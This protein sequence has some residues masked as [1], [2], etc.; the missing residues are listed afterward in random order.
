MKPRRLQSDTISS[1]FVSLA[2]LVFP[3]DCYFNSACAKALHTLR[4]L[5]YG[6][7]GRLQG[8]SAAAIMQGRLEGAAS[9]RLPGGRRYRNGRVN[10]RFYRYWA[11]NIFKT[12]LRILTLRDRLDMLLEKQPAGI[13]Y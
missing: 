2:I 4:G 7:R 1:S 5:L 10:S 9:G 6:T 3:L 13:A 12:S 8:L 11:G